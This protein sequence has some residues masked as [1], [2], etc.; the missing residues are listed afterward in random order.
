MGKPERGGGEEKL[1]EKCGQHPAS[2]ED[3]GGDVWSFLWRS[4][5]FVDFPSSTQAC[6]D[7]LGLGPP[8]PFG[9]RVRASPRMSLWRQF[10][11]EVEGHTKTLARASAPA[12]PM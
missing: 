9:V 3:E 4:S 1:K 2:C 10:W 8:V 12:L 11:L 5:V 6:P 7:H